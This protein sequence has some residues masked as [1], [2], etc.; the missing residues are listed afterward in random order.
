MNIYGIE[1]MGKILRA[2]I[3]DHS[4]KLLL[5]ALAQSTNEQGETKPISNTTLQKLLNR[6]ENPVR[7]IIFAM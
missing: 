2:P 5:V 6:T 3:K 4:V 7:E 1:L